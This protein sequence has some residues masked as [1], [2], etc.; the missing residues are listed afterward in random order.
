VSLERKVFMPNRKTKEK[1]TAEFA[2]A[3]KAAKFILSKNEAAAKELCG[4]RLRI[5]RVRR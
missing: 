3:E 1:A 5:G 2:Q 4:A